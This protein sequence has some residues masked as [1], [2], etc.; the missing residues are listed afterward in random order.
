VVIAGHKR[1][2]TDDDPRIIEETREYIRDFDKIAELSKTGCSSFILTG[3][4]PIFS[5]LAA[6]S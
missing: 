1:P 5:A 3:A 4:I 6:K 2:G